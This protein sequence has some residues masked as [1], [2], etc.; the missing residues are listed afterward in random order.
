MS[1][2]FHIATAIT[3]NANSSTNYTQH[4]KFKCFW[5][6]D[7][8]RI[9]G[10]MENIYFAAANKN[11]LPKSNTEFLLLDFFYKDGEKIVRCKILFPILDWSVFIRHPQY[12]SLLLLNISTGNSFKGQ[13]GCTPKNYVLKDGETFYKENIQGAEYASML[14]FPDN[15]NPNCGPYFAFCIIP[16][17]NDSNYD[18]GQEDNPTYDECFIRLD[19]SR[20]LKVNQMP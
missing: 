16:N 3:I 18:W 19:F 10:I 6:A 7:N 15:E 17:S 8:I 12:P 14:C 13:F 4:D 20:H 9:P 11:D 2:H 5:E 1:S